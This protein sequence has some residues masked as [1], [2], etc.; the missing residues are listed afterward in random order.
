MIAVL[1][2]NKRQFDNWLKPWVS[3]EDDYYKF[4]YVG[5][6][7]D[8]RARNFTEIIRIG[9]WKDKD[10]YYSLE[11]MILDRIRATKL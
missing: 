6:E 8:A 7:E 4:Y 5:C 10:N 3:S 2:G 1:A 11:S 9:T